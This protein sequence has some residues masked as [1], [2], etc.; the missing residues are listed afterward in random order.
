[1]SSTAHVATNVLPTDE[2]VIGNAS[3]DPA[4]VHSRTTTTWVSVS[5]M[6]ITARTAASRT[7]SGMR[8]FAYTPPS[9][10]H[11]ENADM[12]LRTW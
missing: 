3:H 5:A 6:M 11:D 10:L 8:G 12:P 7:G 2:S 4:S 9:L 1:M